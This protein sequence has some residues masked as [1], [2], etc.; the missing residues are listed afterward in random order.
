MQTPTGSAMLPVLLG[1]DAGEGDPAAR[2]SR[3]ARMRSA[4]SCGISQR[5]TGSSHGSAG[6]AGRVGA[7]WPGAEAGD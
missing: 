4:E 6:G 3:T 2:R 5:V 1:Q 7:G